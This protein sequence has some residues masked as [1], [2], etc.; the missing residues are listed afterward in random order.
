MAGIDFNI[1][2]IGF[3]GTGKSTIANMLKEKLQVEQIEMDTL[4]AQEAGMSISKIFETFG[5]EHFRDLETEMLRKFQEKKPVVVS[6]G[7]GVVLRD[8]NIHIMKGQGKIVLLT[9]EPDT[10]YERVKNS[11]ARPILNGNMNV[12]Y[13]SSLMEKRR[14]RYESAADITVAT[15]GKTVEE[16]CQEIIGAV[17]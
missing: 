3:M 12:E 1:M 9:A 10:I 14:A 6:C 13:I 7:G 4:I 15:D 11:N 8:E 5:E 17:K 2:L 16:I